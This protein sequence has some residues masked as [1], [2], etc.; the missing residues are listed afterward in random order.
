MIGKH[1]IV[2]PS[3]L[4]CRS[5]NQYV[6]NHFKQKIRKKELRQ[7]HNDLSIE[8]SY[9]K[10]FITPNKTHEDKCISSI[11]STFSTSTGLNLKKKQQKEQINSSNCKQ[12]FCTNQLSTVHTNKVPNLKKTKTKTK[13]KTSSMQH[14]CYIKTSNF[15]NPSILRVTCVQLVML[16]RFLNNSAYFLHLL[17]M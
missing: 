16:C 17:N 4:P 14:C 13:N 5:V 6:F 9:Y 11:I 1:L 2:F 12:W 8:K 3:T 7:M 15:T 10:Y